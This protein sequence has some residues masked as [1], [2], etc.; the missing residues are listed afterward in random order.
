MVPGD[1]LRLEITVEKLGRF[2][3]RA[4]AVASVDGEVACEATLAFVM[5]RNQEIGGGRSA[6]G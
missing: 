2:S 4:R 6:G 5:P 1:Q 3:G